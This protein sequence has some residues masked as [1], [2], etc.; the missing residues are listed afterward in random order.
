MRPGSGCGS[1][2][3]EQLREATGGGPKELAHRSHREA[4]AM[5]ECSHTTS[6]VKMISL[7]IAGIG[8]RS[9][10]SGTE[11]SFGSL[12][13]H[14]PSCRERRGSRLR[15]SRTPNQPQNRC[16]CRFRPHAN[17]FVLRTARKCA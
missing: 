1:C 11:V 16:D 7:L 14:L 2:S 6:Y 4:H 17:L 3:A 13:I 8:G 10:R 12:S 5:S 9:G 15:A